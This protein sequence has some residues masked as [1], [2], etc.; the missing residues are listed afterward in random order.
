MTEYLIAFNEEWV[1]EHTD[2][3]LSA[4]SRAL[5]PLVAE[6]RAAGVLPHFRGIAVHD[7]WAPYDTFEDV[8]GHAL[9]GAHV[10]RELVAVTETGTDPDK[11]WAQQAIDA[12][13]ALNEAADAA[14]AAVQDA[15]DAETAANFIGAYLDCAP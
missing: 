7:A 15:I 3:E 4:K 12:L 2:E 14:R 11:T 8:A 13:L 9:C 5:R 10:L 6:M 1:P